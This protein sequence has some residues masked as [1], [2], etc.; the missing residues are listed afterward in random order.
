MADPNLSEIRADG[1]LPHLL[2]SKGYIASDLEDGSSVRPAGFALNRHGEPG[3]AWFIRD[4]HLFVRQIEKMALAEYEAYVVRLV[5]IQAMDMAKWAGV[6]LNIYTAD[7][8]DK[9]PDNVGWRDALRPYLKDENVLRRFVYLGNGQ[10]ST[11]IE[12]PSEGV[13]GYLDTPYGRAN[14]T[15]D[16]KVSWVPKPAP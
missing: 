9:F 5:Q 11:E 3:A 14:V 2:D 4:G 7:F 15:W 6:A 1:R 13:M 12:D 16:R 8:D 10:R